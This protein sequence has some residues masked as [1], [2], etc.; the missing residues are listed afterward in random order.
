MAE[1]FFVKLSREAGL[2][3]ASCR[4]QAA[5]CCCLRRRDSPPGVSGPSSIAPDADKALLDGAD[6]VYVMERA[7]RDHRLPL[8][9]RLKIFVLREAV[10]LTRG[11]DDPMAAAT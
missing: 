11:L 4:T 9:V 1:H 5:A 8:Q 10:G 2:V 6:A 7:H 3:T